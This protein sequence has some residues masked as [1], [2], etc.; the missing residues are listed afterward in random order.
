MSKQ[1]LEVLTPDEAAA[2][3]RIHPRMVF[4]LFRRGRI[5]HVR[6][7]EYDPSSWRTD[8]AAI[9][10]YLEEEAVERRKPGPRRKPARRPVVSASNMNFIERARALRKAE[11]AQRLSKN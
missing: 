10:E 1:S 3:L 9:E 4:K 7:R 2:I 6:I 11:E 8:R 5:R